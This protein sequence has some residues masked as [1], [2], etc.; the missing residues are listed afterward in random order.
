MKTLNGMCLA[1]GALLMAATPAWAET[2]TV[3]AG[4]GAQERLQEALILAEPGDE[5]VL[6]AGRFTLTDGLSLDVDGVTVRG[7]GMDQSVLD[8]SGQLGAGEGLLVTSDNVVLREF[9][10][11]NSKGDGIK[12]KGADN[13]VY[14]K[15]RVE[16]TGGPDEKNG[17]YAIYP[18][19]S[20]NV[21][22]DSVTTIAASDAG[23]YVGQSK[24]IIVRNSVAK[25]N[26]AGI[27]I[28]NSYGAD[29]YNNLAVNNTGGILVFDLPDIPQQGGRDVRV[30]NNIV[31]DN[32]TRNFA[33]EGN[34][35]SEVPSGMGVMVMSH[36]NVEVFKNVFAEN[37]T[38]NVL[39]IAYPNETEDEDYNPLP[40]NVLVK[41]NIQGRAG[42]KPNMDGG[43]ML[44]A[45]FGGTIPPVTHDGNGT[46]I[47]VQDGVPVLTLGYTKPAQ[48]VT[49][50]KPGI[51][52][53]SGDA[54]KPL[55]LKPIVLP[56]AMEA[57]VKQ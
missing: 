44:A 53:L 14:Y 46:D 34:I 10:V 57:V 9:G 4:E 27:E 54:D 41:D 21:L 13:I 31:V 48:P 6:G 52:D 35:V 30:F 17:A 42:Y 56:E 2:I 22:V 7:A 15:I 39:I 47:V 1:A 33:P 12:S 38:G 25:Y 50:A 5:I 36:Y 23:I 3:A 55:S 26:V 20:E 11:E 24:N 40:V 29:V 49:E 19:E 37:A 18:V 8:F 16:W 43:E 45:A 28:E 51:V 32:N